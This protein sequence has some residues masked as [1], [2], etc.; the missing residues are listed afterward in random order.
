MQ[1]FSHRN[2]IS[3]AKL[4]PYNV[5]SYTENNQVIDDYSCKD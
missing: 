4:Y 3:I 5:C 2:V 1:C